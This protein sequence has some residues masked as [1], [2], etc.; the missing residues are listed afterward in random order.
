MFGNIIDNLLQASWETIYMV[1]VSAGFSILIG[2][3]LGII[4]IV[5]DR[6]HILEN[7]LVNKGLGWII[8][9]LRSTPFIILLVAVIP[10]TRII[11]GTT[12]GTTAS[13]VPLTIAAAPFF[14]RLVEGCLKELDWGIVEAGLSMGADPWQVIWK[15]LLPEAIPSLIL[16]A[17]NLVVSLIS[18]SAMA[19]AIGGGGLGDLAIRYGYYRFDLKTMAMTVIILIAA[20][21][22]VQSTGDLLAK[23][24][25]RGR[26][27][28]SKE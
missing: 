22:V 9:A 18:Y 28:C 23:I 3:P 16:A 26:G 15:I 8:N 6:G 13:I 17:T 1:A 7:N 5:T 27:K 4:L 10:L 20:V 14:A 19:G 12:V 24:I 21:Q 11:V 2:L 25:I